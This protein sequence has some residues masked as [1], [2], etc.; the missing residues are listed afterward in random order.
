M[1]RIA[2]IAE[3]C[4]RE[5][6]HDYVGLWQIATRVRQEFGALTDVGVKRLSLDV[7]RRIVE[8]GLVPGDYLKSGFRI[9]HEGGSDAIVNRISSE[10][11]AARGDP[12]LAN[13]ICWFGVKTR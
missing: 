3:G 7:V 9:W 6:R 4:T 5:A 12:T 11:D 10:W 13:P 8:R 1:E 2:K